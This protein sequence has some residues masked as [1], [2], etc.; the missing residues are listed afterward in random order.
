L[1]A[2]RKGVAKPYCGQNPSF[3]GLKAVLF[4][5]SV[6]QFGR[7]AVLP[8]AVNAADMYHMALADLIDAFMPIHFIK[9]A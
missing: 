2:W 8:C 6:R 1:W 3:P 7:L 4:C 5:P 9:A